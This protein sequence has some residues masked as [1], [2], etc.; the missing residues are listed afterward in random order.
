[1]NALGYEQPEYL[2]GFMQTEN[3]CPQVWHALKEK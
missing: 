2:T 3:L 1:M